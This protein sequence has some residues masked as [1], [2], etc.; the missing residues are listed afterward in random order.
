MYGTWR[1]AVLFLT[2]PLT[3]Q[4]LAAQDQGAAP[5]QQAL[6]EAQLDSMLRQS[7]QAL[8]SGDNALAAKGLE[9]ALL[10]VR[11]QPLL[12]KR[13]DNVRIR[14][15]SVYLAGQRPAEA[16]RVYAALLELRKPDCRPGTIAVESCADARYGLG[17]AQMYA[18]DFKGA[19]DTLTACIANLVSLAAL[20]GPE[21]YK[22]IKVKQQAD[23]QSLAAAAW[24]RTG[25]KD[26]AIAAFRK[27]IEQFG[28]VERNTKIQEDIRKGARDSARD[29]KASLDLLEKK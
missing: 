6:L 20:D 28:I 14:L 13:E 23:A 25:Q 29:A 10:K 26:K 7:D 27:A 16:V 18:G 21:V 11:S 12:A 24:F 8:A 15:A 19:L 22:M 17:T 1:I 4:R 9:D 3:V 5:S 2:V